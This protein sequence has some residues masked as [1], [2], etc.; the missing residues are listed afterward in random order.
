M[1]VPSREEEALDIVDASETVDA[2]VDVGMTATLL[3][4]LVSDD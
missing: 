3:P 1:G 2:N 4:P